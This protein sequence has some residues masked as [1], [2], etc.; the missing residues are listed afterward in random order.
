MCIVHSVLK[1]ECNVFIMKFAVILAVNTL[2]NITALKGMELLILLFSRYWAEILS[3]AV[4]F[5][6]MLR[7]RMRKSPV[8]PRHVPSWPVQ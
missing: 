8:A 3:A 5:H 4:L 6:P 2:L 7:L 1:L